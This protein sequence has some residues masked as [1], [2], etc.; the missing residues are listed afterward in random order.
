MV[1]RGWG[2]WGD[3]GTL[4]GGGGEVGTLCVCGG[5]LRCVVGGGIHWGTLGR[6]GVR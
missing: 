4:G 6:G 1:R 3:E 2:V 5:G